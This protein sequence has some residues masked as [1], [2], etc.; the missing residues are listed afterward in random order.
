MNSPA[1]ANTLL[2]KTSEMSNWS[3][4][5]LCSFFCASRKCNGPELRHC[6]AWVL[7]QIGFSGYELHAAI[8]SEDNSVIEKLVT[9]YGLSQYFHLEFIRII[10][11]ARKLDKHGSYEI[12]R[13]VFSQRVGATFIHD[14]KSIFQIFK[15]SL[16]LWTEKIKDESSKQKALLK[17]YFKNVFLPDRFEAFRRNDYAGWTGHFDPFRYP[18]NKGDTLREALSRNWKAGKG[19]QQFTILHLIDISTSGKTFSI[20]NLAHTSTEDVDRFFIVYLYPNT[21][22]FDALVRSLPEVSAEVAVGLFCLANHILLDLLL[23][24]YSN[25]TPLQF[26]K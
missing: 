15:E 1:N 10:S 14:K 20:F 19:D 7:F 5:D 16:E 26:F 21:K 23:H 12:E 25:L 18:E 2:L 8:E 9:T 24:N 13:V 4:S 17:D 11:W 3:K 6:S 22:L